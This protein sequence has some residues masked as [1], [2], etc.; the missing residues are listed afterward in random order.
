MRI[1]D[2]SS[3]VC[4]SDLLAKLDGI[5]R[6]R[7]SAPNARVSGCAAMNASTAAGSGLPVAGSGVVAR[8]SATKSRTLPTGNSGKQVLAGSQVLPAR[9][10]WYM[11]GDRKTMLEGESVVVRVEQGGQRYLNK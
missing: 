1:S 2:W 8:C 6:V 11:A 10:G 5:G 7:I 4:S 9:A 3:D